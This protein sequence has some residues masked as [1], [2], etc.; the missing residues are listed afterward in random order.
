MVENGC[1]KKY[2][3]SIE[4]YKSILITDIT[5]L[6]KEFY[7]NTNYVP[8]TFTYPYGAV[9]KESTQIIKE[10]GFKASLSCTSGIN[11]ITKDVDCLFLLRRNN[12]TNNISRETFFNKILE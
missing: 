8:N 4:L 9:S 10:A 2:N 6:Q 3:E 11:Y 7:E 12:R 5:K 1:M